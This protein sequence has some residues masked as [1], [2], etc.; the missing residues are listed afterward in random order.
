MKALR[1]VRQ[2]HQH[3]YGVLSYRC[4]V[5]YARCVIKLPMKLGDC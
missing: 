2:F 1:I 4:N 3:P 5:C